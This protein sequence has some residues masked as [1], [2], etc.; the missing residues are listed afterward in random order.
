M[1]DPYAPAIELIHPG[2]IDVQVSEQGAVTIFVNGVP[3]IVAP[4]G[5]RL[6]LQGGKAWSKPKA[7]DEN[8]SRETD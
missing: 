6:R 1:S 5:T 3:R 7:A 8:R 2:H 4:A